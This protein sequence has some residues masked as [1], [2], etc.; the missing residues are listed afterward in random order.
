MRPDDPRVRAILRRAMIVRLATRSPAGGPFV[1]PIWFVV[2]GDRLIMAT[3]AQTVSVRNLRAHPEAV[4][5]LDADRYRRDAGMLSLRGPATVRLAPPSFGELVRLA[6]KYYL[7]GL[8]VELDE[9]RAPAAA[10]AL[11]RAVRPGGDRGAAAV[12]RAAAESRRRVRLRGHRRVPDVPRP[13]PLGSRSPRCQRVTR[14][15]ECRA[16]RPRSERSLSQRAYI[17]GPRGAPTLHPEVHPASRIAGAVGGVNARHA[18]HPGD[19]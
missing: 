3:G 13:F 17:E 15:S 9:P 19:V 7:G 18:R 16:T 8:R 14:P 11:L 5:L 1:T 6:R 4:L 2:A 12:G 10:P